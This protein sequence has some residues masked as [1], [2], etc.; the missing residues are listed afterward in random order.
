MNFKNMKLRSKMLLC[1]ITSITVIMIIVTVVSQQQTNKALTDNLNSTLTIM[2][3]IAGKAVTSALEFE[4]DEGIKN[5]LHP[6]TEEMLFSF[7]QIKDK[8]GK[9]VYYY[10]GKGFSEISL[11]KN[12]GIIQIN[13]EMFL[14]L[15]INSNGENIGELTIGVSLKD[16][17]N[18]LASAKFTKIVAAIV[19]VIIF[20]LITI[21]IANYFNKSI[22]TLVQIVTKMK[23]GD[24]EQQIQ[25]DNKDEIGHFAEVFKE[26][27]NKL[28]T[29]ISE[30]KATADHVAS[31]SQQ[32][33][34]T[35]EQISQGATEQ[36]ASA[37]E[38]SSAMEQMNSNIQQNAENAQQTEKIA[39]K[40]AQDAKE[41]GESV[42]L[43]IDAMNKIAEKISIIEEIARQTNMLALNAAIEAARAGEHGKGFAVVAAE[44]RKLAERSQKAAA[45]ITGL[46]SSSVHIAK[47]AGQKLNLLVPDIQKTSELIQ[48]INAASMEQ[49]TGVTQ[50]NQAIQQLDQVIQQNASSSEEMSSI[51]EELAAQ[52]E[53]LLRVISF[54]KIK[55]QFKYVTTKSF[56]IPEVHSKPI[57]EK[58]T[59]FSKPTTKGVSLD[60]DLHKGNGG[61]VVDDDFER[62]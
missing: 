13:D 43:A 34:Q 11:T 55:S 17:N 18:Y 21:F 42:C 29:V 37:E 12:Q 33:N 28:N 53:Q 38:A 3:N 7:I 24:L 20:T 9:Q 49:Y 58:K 22:T 47:E 10:R 23:D 4:D 41:T 50:I 25:V 51:S 1:F 16:K 26:M 56:K 5:A 45:E 8:T 59:K 2:T 44:V 61:N 32:I 6:F 57:Q 30:V 31:D 36:A 54:F 19:M 48:E 39:L 15:Q 35:A 46:A 27:L 14:H 40:A 60:L 62:Y 52:S